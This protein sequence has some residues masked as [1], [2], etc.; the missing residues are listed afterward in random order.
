M[1]NDKLSLWP[2]VIEVENVRF[3]R[4]K[5]LGIDFSN[6]IDAWSQLEFRY[7][8]QMKQLRQYG[9]LNRQQALKDVNSLVYSFRQKID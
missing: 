1:K 7:R 4:G 8:H 5:D 6:E 2:A 3:S 9:T